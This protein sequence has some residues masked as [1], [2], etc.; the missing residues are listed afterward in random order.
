MPDGKYELL[1]N[2]LYKVVSFKYLW[3]DVKG[4]KSSFCNIQL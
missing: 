3:R 2:M 4:S 1:E